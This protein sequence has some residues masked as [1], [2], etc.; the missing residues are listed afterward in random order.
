MVSMDSRMSLTLADIVSLTGA[1]PR[2]GADLSHRITNVA[3]I[4]C[5]G[6]GDLAFME[7]GKFADALATTGAGAVLTA[8]KFAARVPAGVNVL[9]TREPYRAF[10]AV[11]REFHRGRL[12]PKSPFEADGVMPGA[13]VH[14]SAVLDAG[15][16]VDPGA[17]I[18]PRV[19]IG[20]GS[21]IGANVVIGADVRIG[22]E[23]SICSGSTI[24]DAV[25]GDRVIIHPGCHIG[26]DGF[27][28]VSGRTGHTKVPQV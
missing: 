5:A 24:V 17:V 2:A 14:A 25:L 9:L 27:G 26:Q 19:L 3:P 15:V 28:Y 13:H 12:R 21:M 8:E 10:V 20:A 1:A 22:A 16:T 18:G 6:S 23:C 7:S 4:D 11:A